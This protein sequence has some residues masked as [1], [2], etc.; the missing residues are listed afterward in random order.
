M[1]NTGRGRTAF[2]DLEFGYAY[3]THRCISMPIE[4]GV[5][6]YDHSEDRPIFG[7][8]EC[9]EDL[10]VE[11]W[12]NRTDAL[13]RRTGVSTHVANPGR[14]KIMSP[15][16]PRHR[17]KREGWRRARRSASALFD[18]LS[19]F[20]EDL[21]RQE[22]PTA[23]CFFARGL[24]CRALKQAG[25]DLSPY[26]CSDIQQD[27]GATLGLKDLISLDRAACMIG[28]AHEGAAIR[29]HH[30]RY[31]VPP[32]FSPYIMPHR[33][34]GDAARI[35]L[36]HR[37]YSSDRGRFCRSAEAYAAACGNGGDHSETSHRPS[38]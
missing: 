32:R 33:A 2:V 6:V 37:E 21:C 25:F 19:G 3:G 5:V 31:P 9:R 18:E 4:A 13:G 22:R 36:L 30:H 15:Y 12:Q 10:E 23:F 11:I 34:V 27:V 16:D 28:F 38:A 24:E 20:M 8:W 1:T 35:F 7:G 14:R 26:P 17:L 29:S